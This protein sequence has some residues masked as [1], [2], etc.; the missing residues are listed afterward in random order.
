MLAQAPEKLDLS[1]KKA[2]LK[3]LTDGKKHYLV[4]DPDKGYSS[5]FFYGDGKKLAKVRVIGGGQVGTERWDISLWD[6]RIIPGQTGYASIEMKDSG[7]SYAVTCGKK[8]TALTEAKPDEAKAVLDGATFV[9]AAWTRLPERLLRDDTG[10]YYFIDRL[11][12]EDPLDRRDFRLFIGPK[13]KMKLV[14]LKNVVDDSEG[15]IFAT[16]TGD[17]RLIANKAPAGEDGKER[18][19]TMKWVSGKTEL[20]L[21]EVPLDVYRN[22][23]MVYM[24]LGPYDGQKLGSPCDDLM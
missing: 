3:V 17:L 20:T 14:P 19:L 24:E 5:D 8:T 12:T 1:D 15:M 2:S 6:P 21:T 10:T 18:P 13:G 23:R 7:K 9:G 11:R 16:Q 4:F 22:A